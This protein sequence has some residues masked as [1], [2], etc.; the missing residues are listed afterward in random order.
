MAQSPLEALQGDWHEE[1]F[2]LLV[3]RLFTRATFSVILAAVALVTIPAAA[4]DGS[5]ALRRSIQL[6]EQGD[7]LAAQE[8]LVEVDRSELQGN[9]Q[10]VRDDY[11][12]RIQVALTM[13]DKALRDLEDAETAAAD[14]ERDRAVALLNSVLNNEYAPQALRHSAS[15]KL[16]EIQSLPAAPQEAPAAEPE[17]SEEA[18]SS[19]ARQPAPSVPTPTAHQPP[20]GTR[21]GADRAMAETRAGDRSALEGRYDE[22][23]GRYEAALEAVPGHPEA[24]EGLERVR[25]HRANVSGPRSKSLAQRIREEDRINWQRTLAQYRDMERLIRGHVAAERFAEARELLVHAGQIVEAGK[26]FADPVTMYENL[27]AELDALVQQVGAGELFFNERRAA[28][29]RREIET[30]RSEKLRKIEERRARQVDLLMQ[31]AMRHRKEGDY[32]T[33]INVLRQVIGIDPRNQPARWMMDMFEEQQQYRRSRETRSNLYRLQQGALEEV[34]E[35]KIPWWQDL[36]YPA[37][38]AERI[39]RPERQVPGRSVRDRL[40]QSALDRPI[41]VNFQGDPFHQVLQRLVDV[42]KVNIIINWHDLKN[43]GVERE[44]PIDLNLP[45]QITLKKALTEILD[46]AGAGVV[47]IGFDVA[48]GA[49][50]VATQQRID[51]RTYPAVYPISDLLMDVPSLTGAPVADLREMTRPRRLPVQQPDLPWLYGDDDDDE[52]EPDPRRQRKT[53]DLIELIQA[54]VAP[55]SWRDRGGTVGTIR[56]INQQLVVTQNSAAQRQIGGLLDKLRETRAIQIAVEAIFLTVSSHYLEELGM[57]LDIV[58]NAGSAG[59]DFINDGGG[60]AVD[61]V[62]GT[63]LLLPRAFSR[64]GFTP[65]TPALG[66]ATATLQAGGVPQPFGQPFLVPLSGGG[67]GRSGTPIPILSSLTDFT[68]PANLPSDIPGSFAGQTIGPAL[69]ILGSFL[70]NIQVDFLIRA[71]QADSRTTV[72]T[73]P[74]LV[75]FNGGSAWVAVTI[76]QN[77]VSQLNP[78]VAQGAVAQAPVTATIDAGASLFV[79]ATVT[80]DRRYVMLLLAPGITRLL[81]LQTFAFSGGTGALQAFIQL[82]VL[83]AQRLQTMVSIPDGGTLLIGGQK[84]ASETEVEAGVPILSKI[85]ILKRAYSAR[86][87]VKDEQTLLILVKP[88][89][90]IHS[91]QEELAFPSFRQG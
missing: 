34:E 45:N 30:Q 36:N 44:T 57:D 23:E 31:E 60:T 84:L 88:K 38:W 14:G 56:E 87:L 78:V 53:R 20:A 21:S 62:L 73:A 28:E 71:T 90:L 72:L 67:S 26:Q 4:Q 82:P 64:L 41:D 33:A 77:F 51:S 75:V 19:P 24:T 8:L 83:S 2:S 47:G 10:T 11:L 1:E 49:I 54:T 79:R 46:Q 63:R 81:D 70:D 76:Q 68:N 89:I 25:Q 80:T 7:Y 58:L 66:N 42:H 22:A 16:R 29:I 9:E 13:K 61:P 52:P 50:T 65:A 27:R 5:D 48:D 12:N 40:L 17:R 39:A 59:F 43:A 55:D 32:K 35:A 69:S 85:P 37:D 15:A 18:P 91:E 6:F 86:T 3:P 74:R